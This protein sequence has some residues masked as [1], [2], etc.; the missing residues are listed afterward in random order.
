MS[1][2]DETE[3]FEKIEKELFTAVI[4][5]VMDDLGYRNQSMKGHIRPINANTIIAGRAHTIL[6]ADVYTQPDVPYEMEIEAINAVSK[7]KVVVVATN[8]STSNAIWGE[9]LGTYSKLKGA[10]GAVVDGCARDIRQLTKMGFKLFTAGFS[11]LDSKG[12]C[13]VIDYDCEINC[14]GVIVHPNDMIFADM[15]G[16]AVIPQE[17]EKEVIQRSLKKIGMENQFLKDLNAGYTL[18]EAFQRNGIL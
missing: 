11:P 10:R 3:L 5:D 7:D 18:K 2:T 1:N 14:G 6:A 4:C 16:I 12:R 13:L 15:D 9:L 8:N 17:I